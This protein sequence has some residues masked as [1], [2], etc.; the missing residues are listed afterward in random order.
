MKQEGPRIVETNGGLSVSCGKTWLYSRY[1]PVSTA[2]RIALAVE[3]REQTLY[4]LPSPCLGHGIETLLERLP[5]SSAILA[6]EIDA[7]LAELAARF[8]EQQ[9][10]SGRFGFLDLSACPAGSIFQDRKSV[11]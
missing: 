6:I 10:A 8:R 2:E 9:P 4:I 11:V 5:E 3:A 1:T 7:E